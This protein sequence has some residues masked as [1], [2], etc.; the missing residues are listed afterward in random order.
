MRLLVLGGTVYLGRTVAEL[1]VAAGHEV[2]CLA[3]GVSA[4]PPAGVRFVPGDRTAGAAY[5]RVAGETFDAVLETSSRP[6]QV[7]AAVAAL[8]GRVGHAVYVSSCSAYSDGAT[9]RQVATTAPLEEPA[10]EGADEDGMENYGN[11]KVA[12]EQAVVAGYGAD[13]AFLCRAGLIVG[14]GDV[15]DR[16]GYW[17]LRLARGG[18]VLA[19]GTPGRPVQVVDVR[20]LAA[21]LLLAAEQGLSGP[22]DGT[23]AAVPM[24]E[25]LAHVAA[26]VGVSPE[27]TWVDQD[28]L[29]RHEVEPWMGPRSLPLWLPVP[30]YR[31]FLDRDVA[32]SL[33]AGLRTR[34]LADTARDALAWENEVAGRHEL[35][36]GLTAEEEAELLAAW[37]AR[38]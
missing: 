35:A 36:A 26:G 17:P 32:G 15:V 8:R 5:D 9:P 1:A 16:F 4:K 21:W 29:T 7:R 38:S 2:T 11:R 27:L 6:S 31:G 34:P 10:P 14:P 20:D 37:H 30:E 24:G 33:A 25:F 18:E 22:Y 13:H 12:C 23:A 28:F 19:P 3:R